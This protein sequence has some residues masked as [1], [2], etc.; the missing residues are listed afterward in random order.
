MSALAPRAK[1]PSFSFDQPGAK[2]RGVISQPTEDRQARV[3]GKE[4]LD[5]WDDAKTQPVMQTRI[6]LR[7]PDG[8]EQ[9]IY[10]KAGSRMAKA[11][12]GAI[13]AAGA[14]DLEV[15]GELE[16]SF[17]R[18]GEGKNPANPPKEY[19]S[20]YAKP[21]S[22]VAPASDPWTDGPSGEPPW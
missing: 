14:G 16:V 7:V 15:G 12:T 10:P 20:V 18:Y 5:W 17:P 1:Y 6:V 22:S 8:T 13:I 19:E 11:I 2:I 21:S 3:Y 9:A 4:E